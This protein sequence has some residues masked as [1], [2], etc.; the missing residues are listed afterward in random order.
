MYSKIVAPE[1]RV[2]QDWRSIQL[3]LEC[4][5]EALRHRVVPAVARPAQRSSHLRGGQ[6]VAE[7]ARGVLAA[8]VGVEHQPGAGR[9][10]PAPS[11]GLADQLGAHMLGQR[12]ADH[13]RDPGRA[14]SPGT[15]AFPGPDVGDVAHLTRSNST[16][17]GPN[18]RLIKSAAVASGSE[19]IV[20]V[21]RRRHRPPGPAD[22]STGLPACAAPGALAA[23]L[24]MDPG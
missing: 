13:S 23:Q 2:G 3:G 10:A 4:G 7:L 8:P 19:T 21:Q 18:A 11:A 12:P 20:L 14:P 1:A 16:V 22:A 9:R 24:T 15:P 5:E 6:Q 17:P